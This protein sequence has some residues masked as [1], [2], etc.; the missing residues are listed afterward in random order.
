M[1][2]LLLGPYLTLY[3]IIAG[4]FGYGMLGSNSGHLCTRQIPYLLYYSS[5]PWNYVLSPLY[6]FYNHLRQS[7]YD[8]L[9]CLI[10]IIYYFDVNGKKIP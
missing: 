1:I 4:G 5:N 10:Y 2:S 3:S 6:P 9:Y 7:S 8:C